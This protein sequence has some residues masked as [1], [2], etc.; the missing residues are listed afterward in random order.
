MTR[1]R[2]EVAFREVPGGIAV[3]AEDFSL[4]ATLQCGQCF[5]WKQCED[6][7]WQGAAMGKRLT[8]REENGEILFSAGKEEFLE[9]WVPYFDL[10]LDYG[11]IRR[12]LSRKHPVSR[13]ACRY[14]PGIRILRQDPWEALCSFIISQ[15]NN[16][17]RIQGIISRLCELYGGENGGNTAFPPPEWLAELSVEDLA[18]LR[19]GFRAK[20][21]LSAARLTVSGEV[22]LT[23]AAKLPVD[24]ARE[25]LAGRPNLYVDTSSA[26]YAL[27]PAHAAEIIRAFGVKRV[28]FGTDY[29]MWTPV[30]EVERFEALPL[31]AAEKE[32]I[33]HITA[34]ELL[35]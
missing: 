33:Y 2:K 32:Q 27:K 24:E 4:P 30:E 1:F 19:S 11:K 29:P 16:I 7:T 14:A 3:P 23:A 17:P 18:P 15:N 28:M 20:Y 21:L 34:E 13:E 35:D 12:S 26:I 22:D 8:L 5:R 6:G 31:T 9:V 25:M 10:E